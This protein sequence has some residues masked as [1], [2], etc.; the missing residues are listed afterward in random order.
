MLNASAPGYYLP[1]G[2]FCSEWIFK[3]RMVGIYE[4]YE[5][6]EFLSSP[7][8]KTIMHW[9]TTGRYVEREDTT[10]FL[11]KLGTCTRTAYVDLAPN[12]VPIIEYLH[13]VSEHRFFPGEACYFREQYVYMVGTAAYQQKLARFMTHLVES[14]IRSMLYDWFGYRNPPKLFQYY[15]GDR[16]S[17]V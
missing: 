3:V 13:D 15:V 11:A 14:G 5:Q 7:Y 9:L 16:K 1:R 2:I 8:C 17:V 10:D 4:C 12:V 6:G